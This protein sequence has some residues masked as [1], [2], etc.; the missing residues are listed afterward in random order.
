LDPKDRESVVFFIVF[1]RL[2]VVKK[3]VVRFMLG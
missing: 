2:V 3:S 1:R